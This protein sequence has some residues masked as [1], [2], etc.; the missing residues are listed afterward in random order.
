M[1]KMDRKEYFRLRSRLE[2]LRRISTTEAV[3]PAAGVV[4]L[5]GELAKASN[6]LDRFALYQL[7]F[8][9]YAVAERFDKEIDAMRKAIVEFP[10]EPVPWISLAARLSYDQDTVKEARQ[11]AEKGL[12][13]AIRNNR[14][15]RY[16]LCTRARIA[17][18]IGDYPLLEETV[19]RLIE[20]A[21][22]IRTEDSGFEID[23]LD[24]VVDDAIGRQIRDHYLDI[25]QTAR[26]Q[27]QPQS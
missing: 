5:D 4:F 19:L 3:E 10:N 27:G 2:E 12:E 25:A 15:V 18:R 1:T 20:D 6:P 11:V 13:I 14:F 7:I 17:V 8:H 9:E 23:F 16:A 21:S 24:S 22:K 26:A